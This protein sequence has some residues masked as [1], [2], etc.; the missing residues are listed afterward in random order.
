MVFFSSS[1]SVLLLTLRGSSGVSAHCNCGVQVLAS[2]QSFLSVVR[3]GAF[4]GW[5]HPCGQGGRLG[6]V[7]RGGRVVGVP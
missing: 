3:A 4:V 5:E 7:S 1:I 2:S 6:C